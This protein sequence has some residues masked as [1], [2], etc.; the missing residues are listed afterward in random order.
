MLFEASEIQTGNISIA[1]PGES[2]LEY[3]ATR[4]KPEVAE[5]R[6]SLNS[7][8]ELYPQNDKTRLRSE[9]RSKKT[10]QQYGALLQLLTY[11]IFKHTSLNIEVEPKLE[12]CSPDFLVTNNHGD[13]LIVECVVD[14][15]EKT[16]SDQ[17][18][19][20]NDAMVSARKKLRIPG[21]GLNVHNYKITKRMPTPRLLAAHIDNFLA[22]QS[23]SSLKDTWRLSE[24][25]R[26]I[27]RDDFGNLIEYSAIPS[28]KGDLIPEQL[29]MFASGQFGFV[30]MSRPKSIIRCKTK[31]HEIDLPILIVYGCNDFSIS[32]ESDFDTSI[33]T[34]YGTLSHTLFLNKAT[35]QIVAEDSKRDT[36]GLWIPHSNR[37]HTKPE[38]VLWCENFGSSFL[39]RMTARL[40]VNPHSGA[41]WFEDCWSGDISYFNVNNELVHD[42][43][44]PAFEEIERIIG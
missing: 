12:T 42:A 23:R 8:F 20:L 37:E 15:G 18:G 44:I 29:V 38:L 25:P 17:H 26:T 1:K 28:K 41:R 31:Q 33:R 6:N 34:F 4:D 10:P 36:D 27:F 43:G 11:L 35:R 22:T 39:S 7:C 2:L 16:N 21:Y 5:Y 30:D 13:R 24:S 14:S 3:V 32:N 40:W 9:L 19:R